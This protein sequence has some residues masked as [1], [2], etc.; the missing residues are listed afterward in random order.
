M[1]PQTANDAKMTYQTA[2]RDKTQL[3]TRNAKYDDIRRVTCVTNAT[4]T[5]DL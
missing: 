3:Y 5:T 4:C 2:E 1:T